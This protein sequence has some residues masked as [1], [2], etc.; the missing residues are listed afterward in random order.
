MAKKDSDITWDNL[1]HWTR[2]KGVK[3]VRVET[4]EEQVKRL[5]A[6]IGELA[7]AEYGEFSA[8]LKGVTCISCN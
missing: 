1:W 8:I 4:H 3:P 6:E 5:W 7:I 2:L